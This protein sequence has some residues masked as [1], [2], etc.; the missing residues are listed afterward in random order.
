[1]S[2]VWQVLRFHVIPHTGKWK[3]VLKWINY[4]VIPIA[5][6]LGGVYKAW[7]T[8]QTPFEGY[9][10]TCVAIGFAFLW[11]VFVSALTPR[12]AT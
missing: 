11:P 10:G 4:G 3:D 6:M 7:T 9:L 5:L 8:A 12:Q 1:M 2:R